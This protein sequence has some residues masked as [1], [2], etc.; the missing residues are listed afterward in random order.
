MDPFS[1][2]IGV[3]GITEFTISSIVQL[4]E[5]IDGLV[6]AKEVIQDI[7]SNLEGI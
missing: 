2:T 1:I 6:E 4:C 7:A 3:V 5:F